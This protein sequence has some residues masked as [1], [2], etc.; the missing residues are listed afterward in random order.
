M[1]GRPSLSLARAARAS[2]LA[3]LATAALGC[4]HAAVTPVRATTALPDVRTPEAAKLPTATLPADLDLDYTFELLRE[5]FPMV[6]ITVVLR[7]AA[8]GK[9]VLTLPQ[10]ASVTQP[11]REI[12]GLS[13]TGDDGAPLAVTHD[14][15][16]GWTVAHA[17]GA[18]LHV[19]YTLVSTQYEIGNRPD[20]FFRPL[21]TPT[22][23][24]LIGTTGLLNPDDTRHQGAQRI[25]VHWRGFK[26]ARWTVA[27]SFSIDQDG[28]RVSKTLDAFRQALF[29]AGDIRLESREIHGHPL[30]VALAGHDWGFTDEAFL[31][32]AERV[33]LGQ[34]AFFNDF[35][36]PYF[37]I[38]AIPAGVYEPGSHSLGG[39]GLTQ[40]FGLFLAPRTGLET[41]PDG[42]GLPWLLGHELFHLW[43]GERYHLEEPELLGYWFSEGFT[44]F[45]ARRLLYRTGVIDL[46]AFVANLNDEVTRY[47]TSRVRDEPASRIAK[48]FWKD[49]SVQKLPYLRGDVIALLVD[50]EIR[51]VS[52]GA[53]SL[54]D[55]MKEVLVRQP[56]PPV[57]NSETFLAAIARYTSP[58]FT[59]RLR[60]VVVEGATAAVDPRL[61]EPCL[62]AH[63]ETL[64]RFDAGFDADRSQQTHV[65]SGVVAGSSAERAGLRDG[66]T[67]VLAHLRPDDV[68]TAVTLVVESAGVKKTVSYLPQGSSPIAVPVFTAASPLPEE[69]AKLL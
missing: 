32:A 21:I 29:L 12:H 40:S 6:G 41:F 30:W 11:E 8:E 18:V 57:V 5:P 42:G 47:F 43:N 59:A 53:K 9:T 58:A 24:H 28:F 3:A 52:H 45:Y 17:P 35:D 67:L 15:K 25:A 22:L 4:T 16:T 65:I 1:N 49:G 44:N 27:S 62:H 61:L 60:K 2:T 33:V 56:V 20:S 14:A 10:W 38:S 50:A 69:C 34:R 66:Q 68:R 31:D 26:E 23:F 54:D 13:A 48:D 7:G 51:A 55:L 36:W 63:T 19:H 37:L 39:T 64:G 46:G